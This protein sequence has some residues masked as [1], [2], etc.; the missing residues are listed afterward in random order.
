MRSV[1]LGLV[2]V[3]LSAP[4]GQADGAGC[5]LQASIAR[6]DVVLTTSLPRIQATLRKASLCGAT[7]LVCR[8]PPTPMSTRLDRPEKLVGQRYRLASEN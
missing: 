6:S 3:L 8:R 2:L 4:A 7:S 5:L 1:C